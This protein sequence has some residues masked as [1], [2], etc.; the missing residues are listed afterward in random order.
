MIRLWFSTGKKHTRLAVAVPVL[1]QRGSGMAEAGAESE[2]RHTKLQLHLL[3]W[4]C[5]AAVAG[6]RTLYNGTSVPT[7]HTVLT[8]DFRLRPRCHETMAILGHRKLPV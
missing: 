6:P 3:C 8:Q 7:G 5:P 4:P 1:L 2:V